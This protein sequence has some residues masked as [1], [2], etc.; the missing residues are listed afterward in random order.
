[1]EIKNK[2]N[3]KVRATDHDGG[4]IESQSVEALLLLE[5]LKKL[6]EIR[7]GLIDLEDK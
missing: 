3:L 6:E 2:G 5:I 4:F 7:C 1:M